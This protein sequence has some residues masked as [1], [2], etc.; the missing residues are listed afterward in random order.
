MKKYFLLTAIFS[1]WGGSIFSQVAGSLDLSFDPGLGATN[2]SSLSSK[3]VLDC[4]Q[5]PDGKIIIGGYFDDFGG[6]TTMNRL[7]K[8]NDDGTLDLSFSS[9][10]TSTITA[11]SFKVHCLELQTDGKILVGGNFSGYDGYIRND[12][13]RINSDGTIDPNFDPGSG[14]SL[15]LKSVNDMAIQSDGKILVAGSFSAF[16]GFN[17]SGLVR[18]NT[19]GSLDNSFVPQTGIYQFSFN[20]IDIQSD[21]KIIACG[22]FAYIGTTN[23]RIVRFNTDG[24]IDTSFNPNS[25]GSAT[26]INK[27]VIQPDGKVLIAGGFSTFSG[28]QNREA[29]VRVDINGSI[30]NTFNVGANPGA[31]IYDLHLQ[32]NGKIVLVGLF[33]TWNGNPQRRILRVS[34]TGSFDGSFNPGQGA[35]NTINCIT[36]QTDGKLLIG[37]YFDDFDNTIRRRLARINGDNST[38]IYTQTKSESYVFPNPTSE[39][40]RIEF[41]ASSAQRVEIYNSDGKLVYSK[42]INGGSVV[43]NI[44]EIAT[45]GNYIIKAYDKSGEII[46]TEKLIYQ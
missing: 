43:I 42:I 22:D 15:S 33:A 35:D 27:V 29:I 7:A 44:K 37:G 10:L 23:V 30:D 11:T 6:D 25:D 31:H 3:E 28:D 5:L 2:G 26:S 46:A 39:S 8:L 38:S 45:K 24:T 32:S 14:S 9:G 12:I 13:V 19:D 41:V 1:L 36:P 18:L 20:S 40:F 34:S 16:N 21:G 4:I 17:Y